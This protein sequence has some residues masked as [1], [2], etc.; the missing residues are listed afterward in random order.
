MRDGRADRCSTLDMPPCALLRGELLRS[1]MMGQQR[2]V[3]KMR[4]LGQRAALS[5]PAEG[6]KKYAFMQSAGLINV[7][8]VTAQSA[9]CRAY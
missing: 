2:R 7:P 8:R 5:V 4:T 3:V 6:K 9:G 1:M